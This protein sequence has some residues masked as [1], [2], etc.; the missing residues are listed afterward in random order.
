MT[1]HTFY[2]SP[3]FCKSLVIL[4]YFK[5]RIIAKSAYAPSSA[6]DASPAFASGFNNSFA[7]G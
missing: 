7:F 1:K 4:D 6:H 3:Q 5:Q 2:T